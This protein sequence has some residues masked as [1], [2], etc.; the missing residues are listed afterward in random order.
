MQPSD[1]QSVSS[2]SGNVEGSS[3]LLFAPWKDAMQG[4]LGGTHRISLQ[5]G[6]PYRSCD[7]ISGIQLHVCYII[8]S[9]VF[10]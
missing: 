8:E 2:P 3:S 4:T 10:S 9:E 6:S 5:I 1:V 7:P